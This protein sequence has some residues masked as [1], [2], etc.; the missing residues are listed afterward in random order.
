VKGDAPALCGGA[1]PVDPRP[2]DKPADRHHTQ[3]PPRQPA[4]RTTGLANASAE[5]HTLQRAD[6]GKVPTMG[7]VI[8]QASMSLDGFIADTNDQAGPL[9]DWYQN[10][11][12][13]VTAPD[14]ALDVHPSPT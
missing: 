7:K 14:P 9:F 5:T 10:G 4:D 1:G 8:A 3:P 11:A 6:E 2:A 13:A 12:A